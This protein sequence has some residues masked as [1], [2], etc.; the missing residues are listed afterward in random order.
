MTDS[1]Y[2][3]P[4][5]ATGMPALDTNG[6]STSFFEFWPNWLMYL[7]V[8]LQCLVLALRYRSLS[9]PLLANPAIPLS[10][11][12]GVPKSAVFNAAGDYASQWIL[13][14]LVHTVSTAPLPAQLD[15]IFSRLAT[16]GIALPLVA[17]PDIGCRGAGVKLISSRQ[18]LHSY[19]AGFPINAVLQLQKLAEWEAEAGVFY[20]RAPGATAGTI[21]SLTLKYTPFVVGDGKSTLAELV[22]SDHRAGKLQHLYRARHSAVWHN[23][24]PLGQPLRLVFSASH[25]RGAI[26]RDGKQYISAALTRQLDNIFTDIPGFHYGR[27]DIKFRDLSALSNGESFAIIEINGASSE[28]INIWDRDATLIAAI[29]TLMQQYRTLF[30]LGAANRALGHRPPG[31]SALWKAWRHEVS[32]VKQYPLND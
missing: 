31:L 7:P 2:Q 20:V 3:T 9:L 22:A 23:V 16:T 11:M 18:E 24:I 26:F 12:V 6:R 10:G 1:S 13:P 27:L 25:C 29:T 19:L 30:R 4:H 14:W 17:K 15:S 21:T 32:L 5:V 8:F 28:S